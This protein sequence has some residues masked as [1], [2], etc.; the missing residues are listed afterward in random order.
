MKRKY[1]I[2]Q[3]YFTIVDPWHTFARI[4]CEI[5]LLRLGVAVTKQS[6][7]KVRPSVLKRF[8]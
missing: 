3:K 7:S 8:L 4:D 6:L 1:K 5:L 2:G